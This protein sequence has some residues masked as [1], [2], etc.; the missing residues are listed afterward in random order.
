MPASFFPRTRLPSSPTAAFMSAS[1]RVGLTA[2][3]A[4][5]TAASSPTAAVPPSSDSR[6]SA[7]AE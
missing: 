6:S 7:S 5:A 2:L 1:K 4:A 3:S